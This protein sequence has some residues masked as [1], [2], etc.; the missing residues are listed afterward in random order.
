MSIQDWNETNLQEHVTNM[1]QECLNLDYKRSDSLV[2]NEHNKNEI[3]KDVSAFANSDGGL[4][5][6]GIEERG[7]LPIRVD[8]GVDPTGKRE[9]L[10]QVI[11]SKIHPRING[12]I[13]KQI[14]LS[15]HTNRAVF[16]VQIPVGTT[17]HQASD[18]KYYRRYNFQSV[19]MYDHEI[20]MVMNRLREPVLDLHV[21]TSHGDS[22]SLPINQRI[23]FV[24]EIENSGKIAAKSALIELFLPPA[25]SHTNMYNWDSGPVTT[26]EGVNVKPFELI[27]RSPEFP[28]LYPKRSFTI[29]SPDTLD[30]VE[31]EVDYLAAPS[32]SKVIEMQIFYVIYSE[33]MTPKKGK[34][35]LRFIN[36]YLE[37][38]S[39]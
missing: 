32:M 34:I 28:P 11:N 13:I 4:I 30:C 23:Q 17:A 37:V 3:S 27:L 35:L 8:D 18:L 2:N 12:I 7:H 16:V 9:W 10:E 39:I 20:R 14:D 31:M 6:Y 5:I 36:S 15:S 22:V 24:V 33:T 38:I 1:V 19:P 26:H 25:C 29:L 21:S